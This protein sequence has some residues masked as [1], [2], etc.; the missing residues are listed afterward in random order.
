MLLAGAI[1]VLTIV[2]VI[3]QPKG[4]GIGW[5]AMLAGT[6]SDIWRCA[7]GRSPGGVEYRLERDATFMP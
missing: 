3:S 6:G 4:I 7:C 2:L 5:S 1:F